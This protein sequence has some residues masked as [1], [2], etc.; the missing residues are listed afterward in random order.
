MC[1]LND[2]LNEKPP[3]NFNKSVLFLH[4][5]NP[6]QRPLKTQKILAYLRLQQLDRPPYSRP[7]GLP[8]V[9]WTDK[10]IERSPLSF[11][12]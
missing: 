7:V 11:L 4:E 8:P 2:I 1:Q 9:Q 3:G 12:G 5:N 6:A 10:E